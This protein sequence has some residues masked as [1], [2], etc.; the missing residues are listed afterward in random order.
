MVGS[1]AEVHEG[2]QSLQSARHVWPLVGPSRSRHPASEATARCVSTHRPMEAAP[3]APLVSS[4]LLC[5]LTPTTLVAADGAAGFREH[6]APILASRCIRCHEGNAPKGDIDLTRASRVVEGRGEGG[7][8]VPGKP[9]ESLLLEVVS[10]ATATMP[11]SGGRL[12]AAQVAALRAWIA[13][14]APWPDEVVLKQDPRDWWSFR[15]LERPAPPDLDPADRARVRTPVDA[16]I[17]AG[18]RSAGPDAFPR[19]RSPDPDPPPHLRPDRPAADAR[20]GRGVPGRPAARRLREAGRPPP[21][22]PALRRALGAALARRGPLRR[23]P[24]LRQGPAPA[25]RLAVSRL[26]DPRLQRG[27]ALRPVRP[28]AGRRRRALPRHPRRHRGARASSRPAPGTSSAT[29]RCPRRRS[30]ARSPA[31]STATTWWPTP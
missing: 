20:G 31:C 29:P 22:Q 8:V 21:G 18:L 24:R 30:T 28:G 9:D 6:V 27:Q 26:R 10:G 2:H 3:L 23:H 11:K 4:L 15:P 12:T 16:F 19:G 7:I 14:G 25:Q 1:G 17:L 13:D 5:G